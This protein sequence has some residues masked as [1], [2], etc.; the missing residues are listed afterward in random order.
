ML[1]DYTLTSFTLLETKMS[2]QHITALIMAAG[3]G[4]RFGG[5]IPKQFQPLA[6]VA[7]VRRALIAFR[8]HPKI[9]SIC[10]VVSEQDKDLLKK[11]LGTDEP[12]FIA[13]GGAAR[14]N[15]VQNG[16]EELRKAH[17]QPSH[18]LIHDAAR[19][20]IP[21]KVID[22]L[23]EALENYDAAVPVVSL[24]DTLSNVIDGEIIK[25]I[26]RDG[27]FARQT[28]Q[29]FNFSAIAEAHQNYSSSLTTDDIAIAMAA[30]LNIATTSG[31]PLLHKITTEDDKSLLE[32]LL[33]AHPTPL[34]GSGYDVH[35]FGTG[36][37]VTLCGVKIPHD[38]SLEGHSD[39]DVAMHA[40]TDAILGA[41]GEGDIGQHFP[42][43]NPK[44]KGAAS[45]IFLQHAVNLVAD[46]GG[47][48]TNVD[49]T[50]ICEKPKIG[51]H[52]TAMKEAL[53]P[54]LR[55]PKDRINIKATTSERLGFTGRGEGIAAMASATVLVWE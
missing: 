16:L 32:R 18:V 10:V 51:P 5:S 34:N 23:I 2:P 13:I 31:S 53:M 11:A 39:A 26:P 25:D 54:L 29:A 45:S 30:G 55:L 22:D 47:R 1:T 3:S 21:A 42:P 52:N 40:L 6:G 38:E 35:R 14:Q 49:I 4:V 43:T 12:D 24:W 8:A 50:I 37:A 28:P 15:S 33:N 48:L 44:W 7:P 27:V 9:S 36:N 41:I 19:P 46:K 20:I 17:T